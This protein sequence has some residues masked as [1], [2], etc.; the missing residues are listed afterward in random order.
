MLYKA[1]FVKN[2]NVYNCLSI[3][4]VI[5]MNDF[6]LLLIT[7][8]K[9]IIITTKIGSF[10]CKIMIMNPLPLRLKT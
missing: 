3:T 10:K 5:L 7:L 2:R 6:H 9:V 8:L 4:F 1:I